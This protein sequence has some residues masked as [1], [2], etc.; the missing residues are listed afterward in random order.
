MSALTSIC[1]T[2]MHSES[3]LLIIELVLPDD[4][5]PSMGKLLDLEMLSLT[6]RTPTHKRSIHRT[7]RPRTADAQHDHRRHTTH[8]SQLCRSGP[9]PIKSGLHRMRSGW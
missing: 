1:R 7:A 6:Q 9:L 5:G 2:G 3:R 8:P 4:T